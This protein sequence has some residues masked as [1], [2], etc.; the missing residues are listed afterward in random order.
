M[1]L[2]GSTGSEAAPESVCADAC[3]PPYSNRG[4]YPSM[5]GP[6]L[7]PLR[8]VDAYCGTVFCNPD[9][10]YSELHDLLAGHGLDPRRVTGEKIPYYARNLL[11]LGPTNHRLVQVR[12]G[13][14]NPH[15]FVDCKGEASPLV[16]AYLRGAHR[17][18]VARMDVAEDRRGENLFF[19]LHRLSKR[20]SKRFGVSWK[21]AG[22]WSTKD[23]G[24][25][26]YLG[27]RHSQIMLRIYEKGLE[28]AQK[29]GVPVTDE[30]RAWVRIEV[31]F[32]PQNP[33]AK[34]VASSQMPDAIWGNAEWLL[35]FAAEA[36]GMQTERV[37]ISQRRESDRDRAL[38]HMGSQYG[39]HLLSLWEELEGDS[40]AFGSYIADL[41]GIERRK[42]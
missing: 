33:K 20:I 3:R 9:L 6:L 1:I 24:R 5:A 42:H 2:D 38:R 10:L 27:S 7:H 13:G 14:A 17:H 11:I 40:D 32:K 29:A 15:P 34:E 37:N 35:A 23:A 21:P 28:Y 39:S 41:A 16:A 36:F 18:R 31:E 4:V 12:A 8:S 26:I 19:R 22:D 30:L 25:T